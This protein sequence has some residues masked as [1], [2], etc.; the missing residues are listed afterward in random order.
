LKIVSSKP[1][2]IGLLGFSGTG[3]MSVPSFSIRTQE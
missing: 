3:R 2:V 1:I